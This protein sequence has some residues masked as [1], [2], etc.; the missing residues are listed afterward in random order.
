MQKKPSIVF[1]QTAFIGDLFLS[2]PTIDRLKLKYPG[3]QIILICKKGLSEIFIKENKVDLAYEVEKNKSK[4]YT[5]VLNALKNHQIDLVICPHL[6]FRSTLFAAR[7]KSLKKIGFKNWC[8]FLFFSETV[9]YQKK[10][11]DVIR[12]LNILS[13]LD[14]DLKNEIS[15]SNWTYLNLKNKKNQ[16]DHIPSIFAFQQPFK[17][18]PLRSQI[19][20]IFPG[21]VWKT[22]QWSTAGFSEVAA[23]LI[24]KNKIVI[25]LGGPAE[26]N[27]CDEIQSMNPKVINLAGQLSLYQSFLELKKCELVICN[28]SAPSHMAASLG[29]PVI[30]IFGPTTLDLGFRPWADHVHVVENL[31]INCRPCG[32]HGHHRCPKIHHRCMV[33][34]KSNAVTDLITPK[35]NQFSD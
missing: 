18:R 9:I 14:S 15:K 17:N 31:N 3:H 32:A 34:I 30:S 26:K 29:I 23:D 1:I 12:Q 11:P 19:V 28:D 4:S 10:W 21:S 24:L 8:N 5:D 33:D 16:F 35:D 13:V 7:I 2:L 25:L 20:A 6:S 27:I 22:K